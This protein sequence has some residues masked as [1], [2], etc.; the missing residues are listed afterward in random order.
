MPFVYTHQEYADI[1][2]V[3]GVCDG[4]AT[5]AVLAYQ[6]RFPN[7]R[8]PSAQRCPHL[9]IFLEE[10]VFPSARISRPLGVCTYT[11]Q[12]RQ[13]RHHCFSMFADDQTIFSDSENDLQLAVYKLNK[14]AKTFNMTISERKSKVMAFNGKDH[15]RCKININDNIIEQ[16]NNFNY[17]GCNVSY[18]Q[19]ED[20]N[21]K[22]N[23]FYRM[24]G[25]IK[26]TLK[27]K[28]LQSTQLK[29]YKVMAVP[30]LTYASDNW[31][32]NRADRRKIETAEM[33]F[34]RSIAGVTILD[35]KRNEDIRKDL[36]IFNLTNRIESMRN[37]WYEH[38]RRMP[39]DR[40]PQQLLQYKPRGRRSVGRPITRWED[41]LNFA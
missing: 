16:V 6:A 21:I 30:T 12:N 25:T 26:R 5:A 17:L 32:L 29:F 4:N 7:R 34:L 23:K 20:I 11:R 37:G 38:V 31:T 13:Q 36:N 24:C 39:T 9:F 28:T 14:I 27:N 10:A 35:R 15:M 22:L 3:Y 41:S 19:K 33:K 1:V 2:Y 40:I 8:I 18:C